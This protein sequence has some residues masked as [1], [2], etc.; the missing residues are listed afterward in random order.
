M[1]TIAET[2]TG[3]SHAKLGTWAFLASEIMLFGG[4]ISAY[5]ILRSGSAHLAVPPRSMMGVPLATFNTFA[6]IT[7]SVTMVLALAAIQEGNIAKFQRWILCTIGGGLIFLCVKAYEYHHK[8]EEG[9]TISSNLFGSF[10][11]TLTGLHVIHV[12]GGLFLMA[13]ILWAGTR[14]DFTPDSHDRVEC[15]GLYWHFVDL[16]WVILFPILYLL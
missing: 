7:S 2:N 4:L 3:I 6:L 5:V 9:I 11:Y 13:Y 8:W 14:G 10:Y 16:V 15:A 1:S 12:T